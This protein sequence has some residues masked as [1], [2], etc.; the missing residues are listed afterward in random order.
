MHR[1]FISI[2]TERTMWNLSN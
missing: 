2:E 1:C